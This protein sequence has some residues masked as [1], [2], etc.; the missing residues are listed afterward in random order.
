M[1]LVVEGDAGQA[2]GPRNRIYMLD[3]PFLVL[4]Q[5]VFTVRSECVVL[6]FL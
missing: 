3:S 4:A 5:I 6:W 1:G 2:W